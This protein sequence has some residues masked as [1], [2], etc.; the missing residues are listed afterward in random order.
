MASASALV[1]RSTVSAA[2][3]STSGREAFT[4]SSGNRVGLSGGRPKPRTGRKDEGRAR[5]IRARGGRPRLCRGAGRNQR[6][7][8]RRS[9]LRPASSVRAHPTRRAAGVESAAREAE[10]LQQAAMFFRSSRTPT[11]RR[12]RSGRGRTAPRGLRFY[13]PKWS[14]ARG[15][16]SVGTRPALGGVLAGVV[17]DG[18]DGEFRTI[19]AVQRIW[20]GQWDGPRDARG[21]TSE[22][23]RSCA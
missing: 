6:G 17:R 7:Q 15:Y 20:R 5:F 23:S 9:S 22:R 19:R 8:A 11:Y 4:Q 2:S 3:P 18:D 14:A 16:D 13:H 21:M 1:V 10:R 12:N